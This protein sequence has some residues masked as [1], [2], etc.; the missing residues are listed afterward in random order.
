MPSE[1]DDVVFLS[2]G[3]ANKP[4]GL[5]FDDVPMIL[6]RPS[7][8]HNPT[9]HDDLAARVAS[10][11]RLSSTRVVPGSIPRSSAL[12]PWNLFVGPESPDRPSYM[13]EPM[14]NEQLEGGIPR[15]RLSKGTYRDESG[16]VRYKDTGQPVPIVARPGLLPLVGT[17]EGV[18]VA[19]PRLIDWILQG[20]GAAS[21]PAQAPRAVRGGAQTAGARAIQPTA[22]AALGRSASEVELAANM[23]IGREPSPARS[24]K[25]MASGAQAAE[26]RI[27]AIRARLQPDTESAATRF[28]LGRSNPPSSEPEF[29]RAPYVRRPFEADYPRGAKAQ[30]GWLIEDID[31][32]P[33]DFG[34]VV[35]RQKLDGSDR[36]LP[37]NKYDWLLSK[38]TGNPNAL[39]FVEAH[40][41]KNPRSIG[42]TDFNVYGLPKGVRILKRLLPEDTLAAKAHETSEALMGY[43]G[44]KLA[45]ITGPTS[46]MEMRRVF[47]TLNSPPRGRGAKDTRPFT[48]R[49]PED[50]PWE[51]LREYLV[52]SRRGSRDTRP[53]TPWDLGYSPWDEL[54]EYLVESGRGYL[55]RPGW[56]KSVAPETARNLRQVVNTDPRLRRSLHLNSLAPTMVGGAGAAAAGAAAL[57]G[58]Q[59]DE[60]LTGR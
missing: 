39:R 47:H 17:P 54:H 16:V 13:M 18:K 29:Y 37:S 28:R 51:E 38:L 45:Q 2:Q 55:M 15:E 58:S 50:S 1:L 31:G 59:E 48:P 56:F 30:R 22:D 44:R 14:L 35:G 9:W 26:P 7:D 42:E 43:V 36:A 11:P 12:G 27:D 34:I 5:T 32:R 40:N 57:D 24:D 4:Q 10:D 8:I 21:A 46:R 6:N 23:R 25:I 53:F 33:I 41:M 20:G 60:T 52:K 49:D 19:L 3:P